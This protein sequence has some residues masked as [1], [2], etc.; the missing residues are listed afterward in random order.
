[1]SGEDQVFSPIGAVMVHQDSH[2]PGDI[3]LSWGRWA[4]FSGASG[5]VSPLS[6]RGA[7]LYGSFQLRSPLLLGSLT[8]GG[9]SKSPVSTHGKHTSLPNGRGQAAPSLCLSSL[10]LLSP[11]AQMEGLVQESQHRDCSKVRGESRK[12]QGGKLSNRHNQKVGTTP[13]SHQLM[14]G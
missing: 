11:L 6:G 3:T 5:G 8:Y 2:V 4:F 1:M 9:L 10:Q 7:F 14:N 13:K 12:K